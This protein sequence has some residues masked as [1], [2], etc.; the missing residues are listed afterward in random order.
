MSTTTSTAVMVTQTDAEYHGDPVRISR[1]QLVDFLESPRLF[2]MRH[3]LKHPAWQLKPTKAMDFGTTCHH[4]ILTHRDAMQ[5]FSLIPDDVLNDQGHRKGAA[6]LKW[7][8]E[9]EG[10]HHLTAD[11]AGSWLEMWN[12]L[13]ENQAAS[14][15]LMGNY[16][17]AMSEVTIQWSHEG[18]D[19]RARLDRA[20]PEFAIADMKTIANADDHKIE[21]AISDGRLHIQAAMYRW[22][23]YELSGEILPFIFVFVEKSAPFRT[24]CREVDP[25]WIEEGMTEVFDGLRRLQACGESGIWPR[26]STDDILTVKKPRYDK[27]Q[28]W[29]EETYE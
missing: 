24:V 13:Q 28:L 26:Y 22:A 15:L 20:I 29:A 14:K 16:A 3:L 23:W 1:S 5:A 2:Q 19:L 8:R 25:E 27:S 7:Q 4:A 9:N 12:S 21:R 11:E 10:K 17:G 18:V 6:W